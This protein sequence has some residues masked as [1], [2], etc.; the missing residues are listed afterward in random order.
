M[1]LAPQPGKDPDSQYLLLA[2]QCS[3][4]RIAGCSFRNARTSGVKLDACTGWFRDNEIEAIG[5]VGLSSGR[6]FGQYQPEAQGARGME[7]SGNRLSNMGSGGIYITHAG[8]TAEEDSSIVSNNIIAHVRSPRGNGPYG[9]GID[10]YAADHVT[11]ANNRISDCDY[12][13]IRVVSSRSCTVTGNNISKIADNGIF[14]EFALEAV[15]VNGNQIEDCAGGIEISGG[16]G[17][18]GKFAVCAD[19]MVRNI[20]RPAINPQGS[21]FMG[22]HVSAQQVNCTGNVVDSVAS[23]EHG[24]GVGIYLA[25]WAQSH[26]H[27]VAGNMVHAAPCGIGITLGEGAGKVSVT[28]N[29]ITAASIVNISLLQQS[30]Y[31][32]QTTR[33]IA[34]VGG[35]LALNPSASELVL[36]SGNVVLP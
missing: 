21:P 14:V 7:I 24:P 27:Q 12:G 17:T 34:P 36:A 30:N 23:N 15:V 5:E 19:N 20:T 26:G 31:A 3:G 10:V 25:D 32:D 9:N 33:L 2:Y 8:K 6:S 4:L 35:D 1:N 29:T 16:E 22:I 28:G 13:G 18:V 11:V